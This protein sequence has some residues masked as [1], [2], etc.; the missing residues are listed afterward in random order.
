[1]IHV[2]T[3]NGGGKTTAALGLSFRAVGHG[4]KVIFIQF[5][6]GR[7]DTGEWLAKD[8]LSPEFELYQFG[9]KEFV[10]LKNPSEEDIKLAKEGLEFA[11][12]SLKRNPDILVLD[13][14][15]VALYAGLVT[16]DELK[17]LFSLAQK[18]TWI[19]LTGRYASEELKEI[20]DF[21]TEF[22]E[23]KAPKELHFE[24][25]IEY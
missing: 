20:A 4:K 23:V 7:K 21:V 17:E 15:N 12:E 10:D 3:G 14:I 11:K 9:R 18:D 16:I 2:Y 24:E 6:K 25:G 1:M 5:M 19:V 13:E 22:V 8:R